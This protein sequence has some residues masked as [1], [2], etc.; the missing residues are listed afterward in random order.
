MQPDARVYVA[1]HTGLVG[2]AIVRRLESAGYE[3]IITRTSS[4]LDLT[5]QADVEAFFAAEEPEFVI[6][7]AGKVGGILANYSYRG[8]FIRD[9]L[10]IQINV[11]DAARRAGAGRIPDGLLSPRGERAKGNAQTLD[12]LTNADL[13]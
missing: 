6:M 12:G 4:D 11:I 5:S 10:L 1:G 9:N 13:V 7:A 2:S 3:D 8:E